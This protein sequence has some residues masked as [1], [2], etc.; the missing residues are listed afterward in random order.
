[1]RISDWSSDVCSSD[2][3]HLRARQSGANRTLDRD[4]ARGDE[5]AE[6]DRFLAQEPA[7]PLRQ[8]D[9][10]GARTGRRPDHK[11]RGCNAA[12]GAATPPPALNRSGHTTTTTRIQHTYHRKSICPYW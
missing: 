4:A 7:R 8:R 9:R 12:S 10:L 11:V 6:N 3:E 1:M 5:A 2:L